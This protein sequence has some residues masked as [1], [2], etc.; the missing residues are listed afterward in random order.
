MNEAQNIFDGFYIEENTPKFIKALF[1]EVQCYQR[2][3][4][5]SYQMWQERKIKSY[6][7]FLFYGKHYRK[8]M[9]ENWPY[10]VAPVV[11]VDG[12]PM[13]FDKIFYDQPV[14]IEEWVKEFIEG[15]HQCGVMKNMRELDWLNNKENTTQMCLFRVA[16]M[17]YMHYDQISDHDFKGQ[18]YNYWV[19]DLL[20]QARGGFKQD[21][22]LVKAGYIHPIWQSPRI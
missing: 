3:H 7:I 20:K 12:R 19:A 15:G 13:V 14:P 4:C 11:L 5:W 16:P 1:Y 8:I 2:A 22:K 21:K 6:K 17:Y 9:K 10:H 18:D